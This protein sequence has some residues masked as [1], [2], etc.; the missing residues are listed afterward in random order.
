MN[1][2]IVEDN[3]F[4]VEAERELQQELRRKFEALGE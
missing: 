2:F 4:S 3:P 1:Q